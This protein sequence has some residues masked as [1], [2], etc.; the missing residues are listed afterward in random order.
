MLHDPAW[1]RTHIPGIV[2]DMACG[3][4]A[5]V[6]RSSPRPLT[7]LSPSK[8]A[9]AL[10]MQ[11]IAPTSSRP[12]LGIDGS[13]KPRILAQSRRVTPVVPTRARELER[14]AQGRTVFILLAQTRKD[15]LQRVLTA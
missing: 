3:S 9:L 7:T 6:A 4:G 1:R 14:A 10:S 15:F 5:G 8:L 2:L 13:A 12:K 11:R